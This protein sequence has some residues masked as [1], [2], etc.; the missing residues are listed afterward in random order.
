LGVN[1]KN[2]SRIAVLGLLLTTVGIGLAAPAAQAAKS[3][4]DANR[5]CLWEDDHAGGE[6]KQYSSSMCSLPGFNDK[7]SSVY[8]NTSHTVR[9]YDDKDL[10]DRVVVLAPGK[11]IADL[12]VDDFKF[13]DKTSSLHIAGDAAHC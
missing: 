13:N 11:T 7:A 1:V 12:G 6:L 10:K 4:C 5:V 8:N 2:A 3:D 9:L